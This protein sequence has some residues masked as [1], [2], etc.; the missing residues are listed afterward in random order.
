[1]APVDQIDKWCRVAVVV[2]LRPPIALPPPSRLPLHATPTWR[3]SPGTSSSAGGGGRVKN[4]RVEAAC[5][6]ID[7]P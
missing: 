5:G 6:G 4:R 3:R 1:M 7:L 2:C